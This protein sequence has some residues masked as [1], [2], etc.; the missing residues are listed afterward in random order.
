MKTIYSRF[1]KTAV[2]M[3]LVVMMLFSSTISGLAAVVDKAETRGNISSGTIFYFDNR[4]DW[5]DS[6]VQ[7]MV[8][9][10]DYSEGYS[11]TKM[12]GT[13][14]YRVSMPYWGGCYDLAVFGTSSKWNGENN[15]IDARK[16]W[17]TNSTPTNNSFIGN[18]TI[19]GSYLIEPYWSAKD[20]FDDLSINSKTYSNLNVSQKINPQVG[21]TNTTAS[22]VGT[23]SVASVFLTETS[24]DNGTTSGTSRNA[25]KGSSV[26]MNVLSTK[27]G[28]EFVGW[29]DGSTN[30]GTNTSYTYECNGSAKTINARFKLKTY[31]VSVSQSGANANGTVEFDG[32]PGT[33]KNVE[34]NKTTTVTIEPPAG[35]LIDTVTGA[36]LSS[37]G[38]QNGGKSFSGTTSAITSSQTITVKYKP[39]SVT[40]K[41]QDKDGNQIGDTQT[42]SYGGT[43]TAPAAPEVTGYNFIGWSPDGGE[44]ITTMAPIYKNTVFKATYAIKQYTVTFKNWNGDVL[45][46]QTVNHGAD[47]NPPTATRDGYTFT[48][49]DKSYTNITENTELIAQFE[50][51]KYLITA[52]ASPAE[53]GTV[54]VKVNDAVTT[55]KIEHGTEFELVA[56]PAANYRFDHWEDADGNVINT[57]NT[58]TAT[59]DKT[60]TAKFIKL[61]DVTIQIPDNISFVTF[62][63]NTYY[64]AAGSEFTVTVDAGVEYTATAVSKGGYRVVNWN[65][66]G[67]AQSPANKELKKAYTENTTISPIATVVY[68]V[69]LGVSGVSCSGTGAYAVGEEVVITIYSI[70]GRYLS[71]VD[72]NVSDNS[73]EK[74]TAD[75]DS[76]AGTITFTMP[77]CGVEVLPRF[78]LYSHITVENAESLNI[79]GLKDTYAVDEEVEIT[80]TPKNDK[81]TINTVTIEVDGEAYTGLTVQMNNNGSY[82]ITGTVPKEKDVKIIPE[83]DVDY[84]VDYNQISIGN[85]GTNHT[86][87]GV[88]KIYTGNTEVSEGSYHKSGTEV[89]F[90]VT[91]VYPD[92]DFVG[93]YSDEKGANY[94][95][96]DDDGDTTDDYTY[97]TTLTEDTVVYPLFARKQYVTFNS[98]NRVSVPMTYNRELGYYVAE[99][100][101]NVFQSGNWFFVTNT[102]DDWTGNPGYHKFPDDEFKVTFNNNSYLAA[103]N[104]AP[105]S[106]N[107]EY[108]FETKSSRASGPY[109]LILTPVG[110]ES[111]DISIRATKNVEN[112]RIFLSN[113]RDQIGGAST[114]VTTS[115][116]NVGTLQVAQHDDTDKY[117]DDKEYYYKFE[118]SEA[119]SLEWETTLSDTAKTNKYVECF[120]AYNIDTGI[121]EV[122]TPIVQGDKYLGNYDVTGDTYIYPIFFYDEDWVKDTAN[123]KIAI[124]MY[125]D[126]SAI[127]DLQ[128]GPFVACFGW[129]DGVDYWGEWPGQLL[130][131]T[132]DGTSY[133][134]QMVVDKPNKDGAKLPDGVTF[135]NYIYASCPNK[136]AASFGLNHTNVQTYD[137]REP[138]TLYEHGYDVI[139]FVAKTSKDGYHGDR[140]DNSGTQNPINSNT[141]LND[142]KTNFEF[143]Y[144]YRKDGVTPMDL[145]GNPITE[146][147]KAVSSPDYY[148]VAKGDVAYDG[149][150]DYVGDNK[151]DGQWSVDWYVYDSTGAKKAKMLSTSLW[152]VYS[153]DED[154][155]VILTYLHQALGVTREQVAGKTVVISYEDIN[156]AG[157]QLSYDGQWY[158]EMM[159]DTTKAEVKVGL[160]KDGAFKIENDDTPNVATYGEAYLVDI[161]NNFSK[162]QNLEV[163]NEYGKVDL[164]AN[165]INDS[166]SDTAY[167]FIGWYTEN[168]GRYT[169][170]TTLPTFNTNHNNYKVYYAIFQEVDSTSIT[171][172][173]LRY[174]NKDDLSVPSHNGTSTMW[175]ELLDKDGK[176]IETS[177]K[178]KTLSSI[179]IESA[180]VGD[181]YT[182]R[183]HTIPLFKGKFYAWYTDSRTADGTKTYEEIITDEYGTKDE[184]KV[185]DQTTEVTTEYTFTYDYDYPNTVNIYSDVTRVDNTADYVYQYRNRFGDWRY[186]TVKNVPMT[187]EE[188]EGYDGNGNF[189]YYPSYVTSYTMQNSNGEEREYWG[190]AGKAMAKEEGF[191]RE[192]GNYNKVQYYAPNVD[193]TEV[194]DGIVDW[195]VTSVNVTPTTSRVTLIANQSK[196]TY[197]IYYKFGEDQENYTEL[198]ERVPYNEL[199]QI[200]APEENENGTPFSHWEEV[201]IEDGSR[202]FLTYYRHYNYRVVEDKYIIAV[203]DETADA[204][205]VPS[206][207]SVTY[208]REFGDSGDYIYTDFLLS[209]NSKDGKELN[210]IKND[211]NIQYG[212]VMVQNS[213][214]K[215]EGSGNMEFVDVSDATIRAN[216]ENVIWANKSQKINDISYYCYN[217]TSNNLTNL[218]RIDYYNKYDNNYY[219]KNYNAM[220][221][222][223]TFACLAYM[224]VDGEIILSNEPVHVNFYDL[225]IEDVP[226]NKTTN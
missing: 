118:V 135:N 76:V 15:S 80:L 164:S 107:G 9:K 14:Y 132:E 54:A 17:A 75:I 197:M 207:D 68:Q 103:A 216:I 1:L 48:E 221:R 106:S 120:V 79:T 131:P 53:G 143:D 25:A 29:Y 109:T 217:L 170:I 62:N 127:K 89:T 161:Y 49:W 130:I 46:T 20:G 123:G 138:V 198:P 97:T 43:P 165:A 74:P 99:D 202:S 199:V 126:A 66:G 188:M 156:N 51:N 57:E 121:S 95:T 146:N 112:Y 148:I 119:T 182:V 91:S 153:A 195:E 38:I 12:E 173:H 87:F 171:I 30:V 88:V 212:Y 219:S 194:F 190:D 11:M 24:V 168:N 224:I 56:T 39:D 208:T 2:A 116:V 215:Y 111:I 183:I 144:L 67:Q 162:H 172:N 50:I 102:E 136:E 31:A 179:Y 203:Y 152:D 36:G 192:V 189:E 122:I 150:D 4:G 211:E 155:N 104:W 55:E 178:S 72:L 6:C 139:T 133:Y 175:L 163:S 7:L 206:I 169:R 180:E 82:T 191:T 19:S 226:A 213:L 16:Q 8:G 223:Y 85:Y 193:V 10:S 186:Y 185:I 157:H 184:D 149:E 61:V 21:T 176:V 47:A 33:S 52:E 134:T 222:N 86:S 201:D 113:G 187:E 128:W 209:Y 32:T 41:F 18:N 98:E 13:D 124:D 90:K 70:E 93:F 114:T 110:N 218:N 137:Y 63:D 37:S 108:V 200:T 105:N 115:G 42:L 44:A 214:Y 159:S 77:A 65:V 5:S 83:V 158:G 220:Y 117:P 45:D 3:L 71:N 205:W 94:L 154:G 73:V 141:S 100:T 34:Y 81:V 210:L 151:Y 69:S 59:A 96:F 181:T 26:T 58:L 101:N 147:L 167:R 27:T 23:F 84:L 196:P 22:T 125:F 145:N 177:P 140:H 64:Q 204:A 225:A 28:Y 40:A 78:S 92:F 129:G 35:Y 60:Y 174:D 142:V 166:D 160:N